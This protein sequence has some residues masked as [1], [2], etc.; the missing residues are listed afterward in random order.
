MIYVLKSILAIFVSLLSIA[1]AHAVSIEE[2]LKEQSTTL[3]Q[4]INIIDFQNQKYVVSIYSVN[5]Q[6][7]DVEERIRLMKMAVI[8]SES[9]LS[10]FINDSEILSQEKLTSQQII[11]NNQMESSETYIEVIQEKSNGILKN[12]SRL[13]FKN[14][15]IYTSIRYISL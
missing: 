6:N 11:S 4:D 8:K 15:D 9:N 7:I 10:T 13:D 12:L 14:K 1:I 3:I 2:Y 5:L